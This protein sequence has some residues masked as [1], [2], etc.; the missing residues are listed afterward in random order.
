[1]VLDIKIRKEV[2]ADYSQREIILDDC[3]GKD[4]NNRTVYICRKIPSIKE[5]SLISYLKKEPKVV[6]GTIRFYRVLIEGF[7]CLLL[8]P[9]AVDKL[10]QGKGF[11]KKLIQKG[12]DLAKENGEKICFVSGEYDYYCHYGFKKLSSINLNIIV[13]GPISFKDLLIYEFNND[14]KN[15]LKNNSQLLPSN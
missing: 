5:L 9:L 6:I 10:Y 7:H 14:A 15:Y 8:G 2:E 13:P 3:F 1:M 12:L 11:G 4:R